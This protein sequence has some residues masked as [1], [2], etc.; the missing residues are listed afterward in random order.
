[1]WM[2]SSVFRV[3]TFRG[4][5]DMFSSQAVTDDQPRDS[6]F[7]RD[8]TLQPTRRAGT[9]LFWVPP[10]TQPPDVV[11]TGPVRVCGT[12]LLLREA[13]AQ[14]LEP[15]SESSKVTL[16]ENPPH[17]ASQPDWDCVCTT[18][19]VYVAVCACMQRMER[20]CEQRDRE[21]SQMQFRQ[22]RH[23]TVSGPRAQTARQPTLS[24]G[25]IADALVRADAFVSAHR[26]GPMEPVAEPGCRQQ[27]TGD[28]QTDSTHPPV[29]RTDRVISSN[30]LHVILCTSVR[31][32]VRPS[33]CSY[34]RLTNRSDYATK[35]ATT[36]LLVLRNLVRSSLI[37]D[38]A[39]IP[40]DP[41]SDRLVGWLGWVG[42]T[43]K[44]GQGGRETKRPEGPDARI[45]ARRWA[46]QDDFR[47]GASRKRCRRMSR[48][49]GLGVGD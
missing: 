19:C 38:C 33:V 20:M 22:A 29:N 42:W 7:L 32:S 31:P 25:V 10:P 27:V 4:P 28:E 45:E 23:R 18:H 43:R 6:L 46:E 34:V 26:P 49:E 17:S 35:T 40:D 24:N 2:R 12:D 15:S 39:P 48:E 14:R 47:V 37:Y 36:L 21:S 41:T 13:A 5:E 9:C 1:M 11:Q 30:H 8:V 44:K 16:E 3:T